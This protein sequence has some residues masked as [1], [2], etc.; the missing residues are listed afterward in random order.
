MTAAATLTVLGFC[1]DQG[2]NPLFLFVD[3][4]AQLVGGRWLKLHNPSVSFPP[5]G[6]FHVPRDQFPPSFRHRDAAAWV[7]QDQ[8][9]YASR[10]LGA[11]YR[12]IR[13]VDTPPEIVPVELRSD[14]DV[15]IRHLLVEEGLQHLAGLAG[16]KVL[17]EFSDGKVVGPLPVEARTDLPRRFVC[18]ADRLA[19]PLPAWAS[20]AAWQPITLEFDRQSRYFPGTAT[21]PPAEGSLDLASLEEILLAA[22]LN[23]VLGTG[24]DTLGADALVEAL[25]H[26]LTS[27]VGPELEGRRQRLQRLL[28]Q[29][30]HS[31]DER[32]RWEEYFRQHPVF[33]QAVQNHAQ[34]SQAGLREALRAEMEAELVERQKQLRQL[35]DRLAELSRAEGEIGQARDAVQEARAE[36]ERAGQERDRLQTE[37]AR[38]RSERPPADGDGPRLPARPRE[39]A[40]PLWEVATDP[41]ALELTA[42]AAA[43]VHLEG[44]LTR[45][46][47]TAGSARLLA[48]EAFAAAGLGQALFFQGSL[49]LPLAEAVAVSLAGG[50]R[51]RYDVPVGRLL[52]L[53][54]PAPRD[55]DPGALLLE[56]VNRSCLDAYGGELTRL[57]RSRALAGRP[58]GPLVLG[59]LLDGPSSLPPG[60]A[61]LCFGPVFATDYL[62]WQD[63]AAAPLTSGHCGPEAWSAE[64]G[65]FDTRDLLALLDTLSPLP[66]RLWERNVVAAARR[67]AG[68]PGAV[69][70]E[71]LASLLFAWVLPRLAATQGLPGLGE[72]L[73]GPDLRDAVAR[74]PRLGRYLR[75]HAV[76]PLP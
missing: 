35:E 2:P 30:Q 38:L 39:E 28:D 20:R 71:V 52:P 27:L 73:R 53:P 12:A 62:S 57:L 24:R 59:T 44:N 68:L 43:L 37:L 67:L 13:Q 76:E 25:R 5:Q 19:R 15:A 32:A 7:V 31:A 26:L 3:A 47:L 69:P 48:R 22:R 50:R 21:A 18:P 64:A 72:R 45:L 46:G 4:A 36:A 29:A 66:D 23:G 54:L 9:D 14:E 75:A 74:D 10:H 8:P 6:T 34:Q 51:W 49:A 60:P 70:R 65:P 63:T 41:M 55:A 58:A 61:L 1:P 33:V 40:P 56:G 42:A 17:V 16:R 11:R